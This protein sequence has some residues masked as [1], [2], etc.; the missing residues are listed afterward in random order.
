MVV[1]KFDFLMGDN[2]GI[3]MFFLSIKIFVGF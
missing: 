1:T 3:F 2:V